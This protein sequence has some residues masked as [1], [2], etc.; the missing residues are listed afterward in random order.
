[1]NISVTYFLN[2]FFSV[3]EIL[4]YVCS[5][6]LVLMLISWKACSVYKT[7]EYIDI[8]YNVN[9]KWTYHAIFKWYIVGSY[10]YKVYLYVSVF[11]IPN[12]S[13]ILA[14]PHLSS[15]CCSPALF[16]QGADSVS[17][18]W[19]RPPAGE[20]SVLWS[21][22]GL[23]EEG[24]KNRSPSSVFYYSLLLYRVVIHLF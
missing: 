1:M 14:M 23:S 5:S 19:P 20:G 8:L 12:R 16:L 4:F 22:A 24:E 17:C 6:L 13:C 2:C 18:S 11:K 7:E 9:L 10:L 3:W 21:A 15:I